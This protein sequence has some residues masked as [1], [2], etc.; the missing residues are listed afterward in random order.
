M[1]CG[2]SVLAIALLLG[3][4]W[5]AAA[6]AHPHIWIEAWV[7]LR[8]GGGGVEAVRVHWRFDEFFSSLAITDFDGNKN[9]RLDPPEIERLVGATVESLRDGNFF[10]FVRAGQDIQ[11][12]EQVDDFVAKVVDKS[13]VYEFTIKLDKPVH[14]GRTDFSIAIYDESYYIDVTLL[15]RNPV[16]FTGATGLTCRSD[17]K[18]DREKAFYFGMVLPLRI[19]V[20]CRGA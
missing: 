5:V 14:P 16:R 4:L 17:I 12:V 1:T 10:T 8:M 13:L 18:P 7:E 2:R 11:K 20:Q 15:E 19:H 3:G 9:G 6:R